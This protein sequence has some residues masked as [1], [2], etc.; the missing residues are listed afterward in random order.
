MQLMCR[1]YVIAD[2]V[3]KDGKYYLKLRDNVAS[4]DIPFGLFRKSEYET[5]F[6]IQEWASTR[7]FP[8]ERFGADELLAE[9]GLDHYDGWE[10][11]KK[12]GARL[13]GCDEFWLK[14]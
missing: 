3:K 4:I 12:T 10:I 6:S 2:T 5:M 11:A 13:Y 1:D 14:F 8:P 9:L 7:C